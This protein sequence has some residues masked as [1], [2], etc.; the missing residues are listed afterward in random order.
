[1]EP[2]LDS[3]F[4][5]AQITA[6]S[7]CQICSVKEF[8]D[9][10]DDKLSK[11]FGMSTKLVK[12]KKLL[13][14]QAQGFELVSGSSCLRDRLAK[15]E[16]FPSGVEHFDQLFE[17]KGIVSGDIIE[18]LGL[19]ETGKT[20]LLK[21]IMINVLQHRHDDYIL[22]IDTKYD[23]QATKLKNMMNARGIPDKIQLSILKS[24]LVE[25]VVTADDL[26]ATL[27]RVPT[28]EKLKI[29]MLDS[30]AVPFYLAMENMN[31][32]L[33]KMAEVVKLLK[34]LS[35][36]NLAVSFDELI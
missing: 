17:A 20:M 11:I 23:F 15:Q 18:I 29:I 36:R 21:T 2:S 30:I 22:F 13:L 14:E 3:F 32:C 28:K 26:I 1:M 19:P 10:P 5:A 35:R 33:G 31:I 6:L 16:I 24:I 7:N 12:E 9:Q 34:S 25:R 8:L 4:S 27:K